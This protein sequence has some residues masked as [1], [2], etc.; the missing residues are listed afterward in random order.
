MGYHEQQQGI[1][2]GKARRAILDGWDEHLN[3]GECEGNNCEICEGHRQELERL[4]K[5][6]EDFWATSR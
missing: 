2:F 4:K 5:T 6:E 1:N 3:S